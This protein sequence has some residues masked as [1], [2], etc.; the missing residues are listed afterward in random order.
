RGRQPRLIFCSISGYGQD[1][2]LRDRSGHDINYLALAGVLGLQA[3]AAGTPVLSGIQ[4]ADLGGAL[5]AVISVLAALAARERT[6]EGQRIDVSM[7]E[8]GVALLPLAAARLFAN[9]SVPLGARLPL[10]GSLACYNVYATAD[11]RHLSVGALELKFWESFCKVIGREDFIPMHM[12]EDKQELMRQTIE[13]IIKKR[14]VAEWIE[15][16]KAADACVEA[17]LSLEEVFQSPQVKERG[18]VL[19]IEHTTEGKIR[20]LN[21]PFKLSGSR[22]AVRAAAPLLGQHTRDILVKLG[23]S[24]QQIQDL[25]AAKVIAISGTGTFLI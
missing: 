1:G 12:V 23:Y 7:M 19:E 24:A 17:V 16:F 5:F 22:T 11:G 4:I 25:L 2:P 18:M 13:G 8:V 3:D 15:R 9:H 10:S 6:G 21:L 20:Q 14:T